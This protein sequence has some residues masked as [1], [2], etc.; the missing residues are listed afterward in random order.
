[1]LGEIFLNYVQVVVHLFRLCNYVIWSLDC[2]VRSGQDELFLKVMRGQHAQVNNVLA[3]TR[4][5]ER[6][7]NGI[8]GTRPSWFLTC[9]CILSVRRNLERFWLIKRGFTFLF[10]GDLGM[11][12]KKLSD[13]AALI[14]RSKVYSEILIR[15]DFWN[16]R[17][18]FYFVFSQSFKSNLFSS[19][20]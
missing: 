12:S 16:W 2:K 8:V 7:S 4:S 3:C 11:I 14:Q 6:L 18:V 13:C 15:V 1:M 20:M 19:L 5:P 17:A 10:I 9:S